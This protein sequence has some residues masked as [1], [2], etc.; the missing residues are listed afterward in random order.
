[1]Q[2][3]HDRAKMMA[4]Q[5]ELTLEKRISLLRKTTGVQEDDVEEYKKT[6]V[7]RNAMQGVRNNAMVNEVARV[8]PKKLYGQVKSR[9][10]GNMR[11]IK[12]AKNR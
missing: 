7:L 5:E 1:M 9:V 10:A 8:S 11:S 6:E 4:S 12:K 2:S 3:A